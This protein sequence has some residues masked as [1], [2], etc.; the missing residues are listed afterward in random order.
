VQRVPESTHSH[1]HKGKLMLKASIDI[2]TNSLLLLIASKVASKPL[3]ILYDDSKIVELGEGF[4]TTGK[5]GNAALERTITGLKGFKKKMEHLK[6]KKVVVV[7]TEI[8]RQAKNRDQVIQKIQHETGF[9]LRIITESQEAEFTLRGVAQFYPHLER[10]LIVDIG[11]GS[12]EITGGTANQTVFT[13]SFPL[14]AVFLTEQ[15]LNEFPTP[16]EKVF[17]AKKSRF[18]FI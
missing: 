11:G 1:S 8:F 7:A 13:A 16:S 18:G 9:T 2:G 10:F 14:G 3:K 5:I 6:I 15:Y 12:T 17:K 4:I